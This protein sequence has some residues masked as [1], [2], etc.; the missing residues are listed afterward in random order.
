[1]GH[2]ISL[3]HLCLSWRLLLLKISVLLMQVIL[4]A[5]MVQAV[6]NS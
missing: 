2:E 6:Y 4:M 1:M 3:T 5:A